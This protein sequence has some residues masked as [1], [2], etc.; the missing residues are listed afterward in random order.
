MI[1]LRQRDAPSGS[2]TANPKTDRLAI[3]HARQSAA[4]RKK[5]RGLQDTLL[6]HPGARDFVD[7]GLRAKMVKLFCNLRYAIDRQATDP[8]LA[9]TLIISLAV[10]LGAN[11]AVS[12]PMDSLF[13][14]SPSVTDA[15]NPALVAGPEEGRLHFA[16]QS[17]DVGGISRRCGDSWSR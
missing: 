9:L 7:S 12:G 8:S 15:E 5:Q 16:L 2:A 11:A 17:S 4:K 6:G 10:A 3:R 14:C 1:G 13:F